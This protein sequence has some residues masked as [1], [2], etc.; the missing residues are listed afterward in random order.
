MT[1]VDVPMLETECMVSENF[2]GHMENY[3]YQLVDLD[4]EEADGSLHWMNDEST[5]V[6]RIGGMPFLLAMEFAETLCNMRPDECDSIEIDGTIIFRLS[7][8]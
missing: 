1:V 7:W 2:L 5:V 6:F 4:P 8:D 3:N